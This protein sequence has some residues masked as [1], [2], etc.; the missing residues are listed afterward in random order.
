MPPPPLQPPLLP[1]PAQHGRANLVELKSQIA[2][3]LG[4][5]RAR[6]YFSYLNG[7]LSQKLSKPEFNKLCLLTL[8]HENLPLH[9]QLIRSILRN[10]CQGGGQQ[11]AIHD[12]DESKTLGAAGKKGSQKVGGSDWSPL[13]VPPVPAWSNGDVM[14]PSV[15][16]RRIKDRPSPL[17]LNGR[18]EVTATRENGNL[19]LCDMKRPFQLQQCEPA[20]QPA[21]RALVEKFVPHDRG[22]VHSNGLVGSFSVHDR[23]SLGQRD[24]HSSSGPLRAPLGIPFCRASVGAPKSL[25]IT[26]NV[27]S[28]GFSSS[29]DCGELCH[30]E[31]LKKRMERIA[32]ARG[33]G[34]VT[35]DCANL[36]NNAL[37]VHLKMLI[38][39]SVELVRVRTG[40]DTLKQVGYKQ[41]HR[42]PIN[43]DWLP[44]HVHIQSGGGLPEATNEL[45]HHSLI[46]MQ[47]FKVAMELNPQQ[48]GE[49]WPSLLEKICISSFEQ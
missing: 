31:M 46:S 36:L 10:A 41:F 37:D 33:L 35:M 48:L 43:G 25:P 44:N 40:Y 24:L 42:K 3:R 30:T 20:E 21:K 28:G 13:P 6:R 47:D 17:G 38:R 16:E 18:P 29:Y 1:P 11:P 19:G 4:P 32:E 45:K 9:N 23:E 12:S 8:G 2:K 34:G 49:D 22:S 27:G 7:L 39:S 15:R 5:E 14:P 26:T